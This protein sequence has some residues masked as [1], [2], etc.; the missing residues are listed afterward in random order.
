MHVCTSM[1][2]AGKRAL[3]S[4]IAQINGKLDFVKKR[5]SINFNYLFR[6][7]I[8]LEKPRY[9]CNSR[10]RGY[11]SNIISIVKL[12]YLRTL[13]RIKKKV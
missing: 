7:L 12:V 8:N 13:V 3:V 6:G 4:L 2:I 11:S 1:F 5:R 10:S 9:F